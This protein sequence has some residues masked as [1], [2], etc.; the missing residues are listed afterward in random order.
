MMQPQ[1]ILPTVLLAAATGARSMTG[2]AATAR[3]VAVREPDAAQ[4][5]PARLVSSRSV[6]GATA[7]LAMM[8]LLADKLPGI[9]NR[10]DALPLLGRG[11]AGA[12]IGASI[13]AATRRDQIA[14][15]AVGAVVA[16]LSAHLS[17]RAR[18]ALAHHLAPTAAAVVEDVV[19]CSLA[20]AGVATLNRSAAT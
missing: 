6:A 18:R 19:V 8:E 10:T 9:P 17:F 11:V 12:I 13:A 3:A 1:P 20:A 14:G 15:A 2:L 5:Q 4:L 16:L 7:A